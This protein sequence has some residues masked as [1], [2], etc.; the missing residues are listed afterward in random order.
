MYVKVDD[1][2]HGGSGPVVKIRCPYCG[3][4]GTFENCQESLMENVNKTWFGMRRCP[5][6][7]CHGIVFYINKAGGIFT[8]P[9]QKI[10]FDKNNI[11]PLIWKTF[12]EAIICHAEKCYIGAGMLIRRTLEEICK[13]KAATGER[14][15]DRIADLRTKI[16]LPEDLFKAM[17][18]LRLLGNDAAH[19]EARTFS[20]VGQEEIEMSLD[21]T[22]E[23][24]KAVYQYELLLGRLEGLKKTES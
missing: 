17:N 14:L 20:K 4:I 10:E 6:D 22:K 18:N 11:P 7:E 1:L 24:L 15:I 13:D 2:S 3:A 21:L 9:S 23:I 5:N 12:S 8:Y 16:V 19:V